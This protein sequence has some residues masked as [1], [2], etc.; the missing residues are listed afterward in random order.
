[1]GHRGIQGAR[2]GYLIIARSSDVECDALHQEKVAAEIYILRPAAH[3]DFPGIR[4]AF[5]SAA[6]MAAVMGLLFAEYAT[7]RVSGPIAN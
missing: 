4:T 5:A 3:I 2:T 6:R 7:T 1:M